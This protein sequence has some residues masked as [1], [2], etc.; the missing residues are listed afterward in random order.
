MRAGIEVSR[1]AYLNFFSEAVAAG[2]INLGLNVLIPRDKPYIY[3]KTNGR[4]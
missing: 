1:G 2:A 4:R 3:L